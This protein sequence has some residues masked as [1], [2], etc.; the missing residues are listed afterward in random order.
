MNN[1]AHNLE[2]L[3][4]EIRS[5]CKTSGRNPSDIC[6]IAVS[7][8]K[9]AGLIKEAYD[10]GQMDIGES[11]VQEFLEKESSDQLSELPIRW[12]FIGHL[13]SN[14]VKDIVGKVSLVHSIDKLGTAE[15][16]SKRASRKNI[17]VDY[18]VEIN[19][20]GEVSKFGLPPDE[21]LPKAAHF[22][23]LPNIRLR[24]LMTI[25]SPDRKKA[26]YEFR[27]L[28]DLLEQL[29]EASPDPGLLTE[30]SMGMSQDYDIAIE[31]GATMI[32]IGT[33]IF[34]SRQR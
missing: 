1:I 32:R 25:A 7:K 19:T 6:L 24:G 17:I 11:Y 30:L 23:N 8:T 33:A 26:R 18:L 34:G 28:A 12:H 4:E 10:A 14:K 22:F 29:R 13:Q 16:L 5:V 2:H 20:S 21:L 3:H 27:M 15:E 9:P 31:E